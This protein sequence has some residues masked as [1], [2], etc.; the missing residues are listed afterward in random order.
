M[1]L[2]LDVGETDAATTQIIQTTVGQDLEVWLN[3]GYTKRIVPGDPD[4]SAVFYRMSQ[5]TMMVQMPPV[6][7]EF[8][9]PNGLDLVRTWIQSL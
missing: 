5:R 1:I 6:A 9:D 8:T 3:H 2:R 7:T 4:Q